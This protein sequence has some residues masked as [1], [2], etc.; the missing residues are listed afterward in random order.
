M[1][2]YRISTFSIRSGN[3]GWK[4]LL[5]PQNLQMITSTL[6]YLMC[7][8][9]LVFIEHQKLGSNPRKAFFISQEK[10]FEQM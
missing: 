3:I 7:K 2:C 6:T 10:R 9:T 1:R 5:T 8:G 4:T